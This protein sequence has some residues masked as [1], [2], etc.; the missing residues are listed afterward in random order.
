VAVPGKSHEY[1]GNDE[2][3]YCIEASHFRIVLK[4]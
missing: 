4:V 2:E 1:V 3:K